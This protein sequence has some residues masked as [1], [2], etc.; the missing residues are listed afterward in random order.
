MLGKG[1]GG[2]G[3]GRK[4]RE[5]STWIFV[6]EPRVPRD[7]TGSML[8]DKRLGVSVCLWACLSVPS[9]SAREHISKT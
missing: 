1:E 7:A 6:Q 3:R 9:L 5:G 8:C 2:S 4:G